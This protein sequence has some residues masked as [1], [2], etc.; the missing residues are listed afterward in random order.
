[1]A[2]AMTYEALAPDL[3]ERIPA[4]S[5][6]RAVP[7]ARTEGN[8]GGVEV[9]LAKRPTRRVVEGAIAIKLLFT[10]WRDPPSRTR[11]MRLHERETPHQ[12]NA[13]SR[14]DRAC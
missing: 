12:P 4:S 2:P 14:P 3:L 6:R 7:L 13:S 10:L 9:D 11:P 5:L 8:D 1:M